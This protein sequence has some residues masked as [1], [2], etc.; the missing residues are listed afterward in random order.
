MNPVKHEI[1]QGKNT[2]EFAV[3]ICEGKYDDVIYKYGNVGLKEIN[4]ECRL[5]FD[6]Y[7]LENGDQVKDENDFKEVAGD[8]LVDILE[9]HSSE[10]GYG[11]DRDNN[12]EESG[13][14]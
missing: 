7:L 13:S 3:K 6:Y 2:G 9:N 1:V 5:Y 4:E 8:I 10:I 12:S 14:Q 11:N